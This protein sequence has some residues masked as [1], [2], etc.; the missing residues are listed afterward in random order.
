MKAIKI[1]TQ[2]SKYFME[3]LDTNV[4]TE[5]T[6]AKFDKKSQKH[7]F[8]LPENSAN[9]S[10][11]CKETIDEKGE[12]TR[13]EKS[14]NHTEKLT[15][16][17]KLAPKFNPEDYLDEKQIEK[18]RKLLEEVAKIDAIAEAEYKKAQALSQL[19]ATLKGLDADTLKALMAKMNGES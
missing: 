13:D 11:V 18:R 14:V 2:D 10:L 19:E 9:R 15:T 1:Y 4:T 5:L 12:L 7:W 8:K 6:G 16:A 17:R 3:D